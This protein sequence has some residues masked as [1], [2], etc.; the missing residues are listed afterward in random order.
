MAKANKEQVEVTSKD[1]S[2]AERIA[3]FK[4]SME[5]KYGEN[6]MINGNQ[7]SIYHE[8]VS[9]GSI[10]LDKAIGIG[11]LPRG[12]ITEIFGP[13]SSGK[14]TIAISVMA[15]AM[16]DKDIHCGFVDV[17]HAYDRAYGEKL[18]IDSNRLTIG[19][20]DNGDDALEMARQMCISGDYDVIVVDSVAALVPKSEIDGDAEIG[21]QRP[22]NQ[23]RLMSQGCRVLTPVIAKSN[24]VFIFI[25]QLRDKPNMGGGGR[26]GMPTPQVTSGGN[27]LKF[28]AAVRLDVKRYYSK[29]VDGKQGG[30]IMD[31]EEMIGNLTK[32]KVIKNKVSPPFRACEFNILFGEGIDKFSEIIQM[33]V[34]AGVIVKGGSWY[35][36]NDTNL[37][38]GI[39]SVKQAMRDNEEM[40]L[41]VKKKVEDTFVPTEFAPSDED[42]ENQI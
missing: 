18:G 11:G 23:A 6:T 36:Y 14:T 42:I 26:P 13:E 12:K 37:G 40:Y 22:A 33:G 32:V 28:Y 9:T 34:E 10:G 25:N 2:K 24:C 1:L 41:E 3:L 7:G 31:G 29:G 19:K 8:H 27:A 39:E 15:E 30:A 38:Q 35:K 16:K 20:P 4:K 5:K 17:E 21:D